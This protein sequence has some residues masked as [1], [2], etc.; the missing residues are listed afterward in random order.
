MGAISRKRNRQS[1]STDLPEP[2]A[3][4][5]ILF[6]E[7]RS[8]KY[9]GESRYGRPGSRG[10]RLVARGSRAQGLPEGTRRKP[11]TDG[12]ANLRGVRYCGVARGAATE[13]VSYIWFAASRGST[14][15]GGED[16][17][18]FAPGK[19]GS[20]P[21]FEARTVEVACE[22]RRAPRLRFCREGEAELTSLK[23]ISPV[24]QRASAIADAQTSA[25]RW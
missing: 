5:G 6:S 16:F 1:A 12:R 19:A 23:P 10:S 11:D 4:E 17:G 21:A 13:Y 14:D 24:P 8:S 15:A 18:Y 2:N 9:P 22:G 7:A 20:N 3:P 25:R